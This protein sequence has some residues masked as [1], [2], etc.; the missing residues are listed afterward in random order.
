MLTTSIILNC[1]LII[2]IAS[3]FHYIDK[4]EKESNERKVQRQKQVQNK[5]DYFVHQLEL[6]N[7]LQEIFILHIKIWANGIRHP[8]FGPDKNGM[9]RTN[10]IL[11]MTPN[12]VYLGNIWGLTTNPLPFWEKQDE[13]TQNLVINQYRNILLTN[14]RNLEF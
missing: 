9:F 4:V 10:D 7:T 12:E 2:A 11:M 3:I 8:N 5:I 6:A 1:I 13:Q 14:I